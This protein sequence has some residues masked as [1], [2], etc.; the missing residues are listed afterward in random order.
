[1]TDFLWLLAIVS[2]SVAV[3]VWSDRH[4]PRDFLASVLPEPDYRLSDETEAARAE[5]RAAAADAQAKRGGR[6]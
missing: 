5:L 1:M 2:T 4:A 6:R 3:V